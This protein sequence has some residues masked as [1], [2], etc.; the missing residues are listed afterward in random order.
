MGMSNAA[1]TLTDLG[2]SLAA[3][4]AHVYDMIGYAAANTSDDALEFVSECYDGAGDLTYDDA[5][6]AVARYATNGAVADV[7]GLM[8]GREF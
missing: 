3:V 2:V 7:R 6:N 8:Y 5:A 4:V 1:K